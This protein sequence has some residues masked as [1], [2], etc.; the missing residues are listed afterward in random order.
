MPSLTIENG[1]RPD[2]NVGKSFLRNEAVPMFGVE[3]IQPPVTTARESILNK[4]GVGPELSQGIARATEYMRRLENTRIYQTLGIDMILPS[5]T[6]ILSTV[7]KIADLD[8][9]KLFSTTEARIY[10]EF[11]RYAYRGTI[12]S[13]KQL[14]IEKTLGWTGLINFRETSI[15]NFKLSGTVQRNLHKIGAG[16]N[17][18]DILKTIGNIFGVTTG[19]ASVLKEVEVLAE[20]TGQYVYRFPHVLAEVKRT[21]TGVKSN[22]NTLNEIVKRYNGDEIEL[23]KTYSRTQDNAVSLVDHQV[24]STLKKEL[25]KSTDARVFGDRDKVEL[26]NIEN[27]TR[28]SGNLTDKFEVEPYKLSSGESKDRYAKLKN[29]DGIEGISTYAKCEMLDLGVNNFWSVIIK[30]GSYAG[31]TNRLFEKLPLPKFDQ[32]G[33]LP[34]VGCKFNKSTP[35]SISIKYPNFDLDLPTSILGPDEFECTVVDDFRLRF[36]TWLD[37]YNKFLY[38]PS[39][40]MTIPYLNRLFE[41]DIWQYDRSYDLIYSKKFLGILKP[42]AL[43]FSGEDSSAPIEHTLQFQLVGEEDSSDSFPN[44]TGSPLK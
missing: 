15:P 9:E 29:I 20:V 17:L 36:T 1:L 33:W 21:S 16:T 12:W 18:A 30:K 44:F 43:N 34:I 40:R 31:S 25:S 6:S 23:G 37:A 14:I 38:N 19:G 4:M 2:T 26:T 42:Q 32:N 39:T 35:S 24:D 3:V 22:S 8:P 27:N 7:Q 13:I 11:H 41:I 5:A 28:K 10:T